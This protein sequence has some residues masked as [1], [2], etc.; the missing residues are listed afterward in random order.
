[1]DGR[2]GVLFLI[3]SLFG[4]SYQLDGFNVNR[5]DFSGRAVVSSGLLQ[6]KDEI[7]GQ[8]LRLSYA[9]GEKWGRF[10]PMI[11]VSITDQGGFWAGVGLY[12]QFDI[13]VGNAD[14]FAGFYLA[15]G[16]YVKG[17]EVDLGFPIEIR[18]GIEFGVRLQNDWQVSLSYD[19]RSNADVVE[20]NPGLETIQVRFSK[21]FRRKY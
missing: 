18:S 8:E 11:D 17:N 1:M 3:M 13:E 5:A 15:P 7:V 19:H 12:Q 16:I 6:Y 4:D 10:N 21:P 20:W 14:L 2:L 9:F